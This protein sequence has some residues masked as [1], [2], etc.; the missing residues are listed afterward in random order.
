MMII[1]IMNIVYV[2]CRFWLKKMSLGIDSQ[3]QI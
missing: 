3:T 2:F 1:R